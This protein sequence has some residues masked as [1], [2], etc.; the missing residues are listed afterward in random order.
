MSPLW[1]RSSLA[2]CTWTIPL[3]SVWNTNLGDLWYHLP[4]YSKATVS[5]VSGHVAYNRPENGVSALG[6]Q[7]VLGLGNYKTAWAMLHKLRRA[8]V[9][10]GREQLH[11]TVEVDEAYWGAEETG[12]RGRLTVAKALI[13]VAAEA[14]GTGIGRIRLRPIPDTRGDLASFRCS[15]KETI[16]PL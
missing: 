5:L 3:C 14:D 8:M 15:T 13:A 10:P 6:L 16:P 1:L 12:V 7:R 4:S 9:R 2:D 11:G